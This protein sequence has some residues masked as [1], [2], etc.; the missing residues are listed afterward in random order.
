MHFP[1]AYVREGLTVTLAW[2]GHARMQYSL[3]EHTRGL[4]ALERNASLAVWYPLTLGIS[5]EYQ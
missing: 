3:I 2:K 1:S 4:A 5:D